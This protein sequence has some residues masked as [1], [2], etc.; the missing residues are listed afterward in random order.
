MSIK[1][2]HLVTIAFA[3]IFMVAIT[4]TGFAR[5]HR[6]PRIMTTEY[7]TT[8]QMLLANEIN[9]SGEP[10][11]EALGYNLDDLDPA[12][13]GAPDQIAYSLGIEN[14]EYSRYQLGTV[15][16]RSGIGL[17]MMWAPVIGRM[18]AMEPDGFDGSFT[19]TPNGFNEDDEL[20]KNIRMIET[21]SGQSAPANPWPQFAEFVG[22]DPHLPQAVDPD[23]FM[24]DFSTLRW[25]RSRMHKVLNP[26]AM[27]QSLMKQYLWAQ[28]MLSAFHDGDDNGIDADGIVS[29]D[30]PGSPIFDPDNNVFFGGDSL[31]GFIGM[32]LT[33][34]AINKVV[35]LTGQLAY[36]GE[37]L[38]AID[39]M[40]YNPANGLQYFV[41]GV[42]VT[43]EPVAPGLPPH[44]GTLDVVD[45][46]SNLFDQASLLWGLV[47][48]VNMMDPSDLSD[49]PHLAYRSVFDGQPFPGSMAETGTPGPY[50]LMKGTSRA[51]FLNLQAM[52]YNAEHQVFVDSAVLDDGQVSQSRLVSVQASTYLIVALETF[53]EEFVGTPLE[54][55]AID[56]LTSQAQ[57]MVDHLSYGAGWYFTQTRLGHY[58]WR[59]NMAAQAAAVRGLYVAAR[60]TG[61]PDFHA[62]ADLA[63]RRLIQTY[64]L[65]DQALFRTRLFGRSAVFTPRNFAVLAGALREA[66]LEGGHVEAPGIYTAVWQNVANR[67]QLSEGPATGE[68][69]HD[70]DG[71]GMPFIP[72]QPD[73]LPPVF[74][75][76]GVFP[77]RGGW[78]WFR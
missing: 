3:A 70:S 16:S 64:Y 19:P 12:I 8:D 5:G 31:D 17:H 66:A 42:A 48:F 26:A 63:Y 46:H 52:H 76:R 72:E 78:G 10:F 30:L 36:D 33:A 43:E 39:L 47:S 4:T 77:I 38:G 32:L 14:Y 60:V 34:E 71:D 67:M 57:F 50:D 44:L 9:E 29:P 45:S 28:D 2:A 54:Q 24:T 20:I 21:L 13:L 11:A 58:P 59:T 53:I 73:G 37:N 25:D 41:S 68:F 15:I 22:G 6:G 35:F 18:A 1:K 62:A 40:N 69:G 74:A 61:D 51:I 56:A 49:A 23:N 27:G 75:T 65:D 7:L 55:A